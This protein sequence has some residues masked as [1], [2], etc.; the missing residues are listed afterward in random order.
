MPIERVKNGVALPFPVLAPDCPT[1][2]ALTTTLAQ[3]GPLH[4]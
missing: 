3:F 1:W 2:A 4:D